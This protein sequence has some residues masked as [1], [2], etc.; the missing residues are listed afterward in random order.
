MDRTYFLFRTKEMGQ[1]IKESKRER[2][3]DQWDY[4]ESS[5]PRSYIKFT[6]ID[7]ELLLKKII[8]KYGR[9]NE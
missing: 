8:K 1:Y 7:K 2:Y 4:P 3:S 9:K 6:K 5:M